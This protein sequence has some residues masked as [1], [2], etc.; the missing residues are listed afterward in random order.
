MRP[1]A[2]A[3]RP[4][5]T[6]SVYQVYQGRC[7]HRS[8][9]RRREARRART[10]SRPRAS[11]TASW[12]PTRALMAPAAAPRPRRARPS[13]ELRW[14]ADRSG[15]PRSPRR[16]GAPAP[17]GPPPAR[18]PA[19]SPGSRSSPRAAGRERRS[20]REGRARAG[21]P[22]SPDRPPFLHMWRNGGRSGEYGAPARARPSRA[23]R[24]SRPAARGEERDP[25]D[26]AGRR[27][28]GGP[29]GAGAPVRRGDRGAPERSARQ[30]SSDEGRARRGRGAA[31]GAM[32][33]R[34]G[35]HDAVFEAR[36]R[37]AVRARLASR[38]RCFERWRQRPWY[39]WYTEAVA[40]GR[41]AVANGR[42][43]PFKPA[44]PRQL[45]SV[46]VRLRPFSTPAAKGSIPGASTLNPAATRGFSLRCT[47]GAGNV[48]RRIL[49]SARIHCAST[50]YVGTR[51]APTSV[52]SRLR[53]FA[54]VIVRCRTIHHVLSAPET[55]DTR[56]L[57]PAHAEA[58]ADVHPWRRRQLHDEIRHAVHRH[59]VPFERLAHL[60]DLV[61]DLVVVGEPAR[62]QKGCNRSQR[63][64]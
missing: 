13:S 15:A 57:P 16:T 11:N 42:I 22:Y 31:A 6:A 2:T 58:S 41:I 18:R 46:L 12:G 59:V 64:R 9:H 17:G 4:D 40:S 48:T 23:E 53:P 1:F 24:R 35:P 32:S 51:L 43:F 14:R 39:T 25:G 26:P 52:F 8:K 55:T 28:G 61:R 36:G 29:P 7:R 38:R 34:V 56:E 54:T 49:A 33:A 27:A 3:I 37:D 5:A 62:P 19:G 44:D 30:R 21:A 20:A 47:K 63:P 60:R 45:P 10:A 50:W